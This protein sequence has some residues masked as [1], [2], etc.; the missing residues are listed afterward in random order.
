MKERISIKYLSSTRGFVSS[1]CLCSSSSLAKAASCSQGNLY[2]ENF[3]LVT[4]D[5][6]KLINSFTSIVMKE[7]W[8]TKIGC[9]LRGC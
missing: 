3:Y 1:R 5:G 8:F 4:S 7:L 2:L 9:N 6:S